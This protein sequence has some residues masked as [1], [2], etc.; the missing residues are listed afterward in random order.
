MAIDAVKGGDS[1][2]SVVFALLPDWPAMGIWREWLRP[3]DTFVDVGA[4]VGLYT[5]LA[6]EC[7]CRVI[8]VEPAPD[9]AMRL[10]HH[11]RLNGCADVVVY[12]CALMDKPGRVRMVGPDANRRSAQSSAG[13]GSVEARTLD[14]VMGSSS[15]RGMKI[16]VE[17][18]E[19]L[20]LEGS[21]ALLADGRVELIQLEWNSTS[22]AAL[23]EDRRPLAQLLRTA[24]FTLFQAE[25]FRLVGP[26]DEPAFGGDVFAARHEA[27]ESL[28]AWR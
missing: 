22:L 25:G 11:V 10:R 4:N 5:L 17:G 6:A 23:D 18:N 3:G 15:I 2:S 1:S 7:G 28:S 9:M 14:E 27:L 8:A 20:V 26:L 21:A 16:D 13:E 19:R 12:E 24:G